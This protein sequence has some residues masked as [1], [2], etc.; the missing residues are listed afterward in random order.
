MKAIQ[1]HEFGGPEV[2]KFEEAEEPSAGPGQLLIQVRAA[3]VNPVDTTFRSGAH[4][5]SKSL[6]LPWTPGI[7]AAGEVIEVGEGVEGFGAGDR[8]FGAAMT[9]S[10]AEKTALNGLRT[11]RIPSNLSFEECASFPVVLYTAFNAVVVKAGIQPGQT[12]LVHAGAGGVG[13]MAIQIAKAAGARVIT[14]V[15]SKEKAAVAESLGADVVVNYREEDFAD[16]CVAESGGVGVDVVIEMVSAENF[17]ESCR[18]LKKGGTMVLLGAGT[19]KSMVG[20]VTYPP[21]YSKDI[22]VR[23][24]SLFN[25]DAVFPDMI[26][27]VN[28]LLEQGKVRALVGEEIPLAEAARAHE[29]LMTGKVAGKIVLKV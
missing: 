16:R 24:M 5:L 18:A 27:Q 12:I 15:S 25:T 9:G 22:D 6:K 11:A 26:R 3:G 1:V 2:M 8:V 10:Y 17:D 20:S 21:F 7:D 13:S 14:T 29:V 28:Y 23:G 19:G 4:P